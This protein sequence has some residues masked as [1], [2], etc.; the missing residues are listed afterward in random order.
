MVKTVWN[1]FGKRAALAALGSRVQSSR[2]N[3]KLGFALLKDRRIG[4]WSKLIAMALGVGGVGAL[5]G[6]ELPLE[7]VLAVLAPGVGLG[8]DLVANG[9]EAVLLPFVFAALLLPYVA[10]RALVDRILEE[11]ESALL[12]ALPALNTP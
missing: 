11:R 9:L 10:P 2:F 12:P 7:A 8:I 4:F 3:I 1:R 5:V 6:L